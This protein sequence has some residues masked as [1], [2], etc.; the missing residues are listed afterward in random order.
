MTTRAHRNNDVNRDLFLFNF[1]MTLVYL[2]HSWRRYVPWR[3]RGSHGAGVNSLLPLCGPRDQIAITRPSNR[4]RYLLDHLNA[5]DLCLKLIF[6]SALPSEVP[7][8]TPCVPL[9]S[10]Q[11]AH[12]AG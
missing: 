3:A 4:K 11:M 2:F 7:S 10:L 12:I 8:F 1:F 6:F 5:K 9:S